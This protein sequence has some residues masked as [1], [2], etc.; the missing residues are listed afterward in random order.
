MHA[1]SARATPSRTDG[2]EHG[3]GRGTPALLT[4][5]SHP[6]HANR[7]W[8]G[9]SPPA[10]MCRL[11]RRRSA[12]MARPCG[13]WRTL[14]RP[15]SGVRGDRQGERAGNPACRADS[16]SSRRWRE[17]L[18]GGSECRR[19]RA[20]RGPE[21]SRPKAGRPA[22]QARRPGCARPPPPAFPPPERGDRHGRRRPRGRHRRSPPATW[23]ARPAPPTALLRRGAPGE[24]GEGRGQERERRRRPMLVSRVTLFCG[25]AVLAA[26]RAPRFAP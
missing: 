20:P 23:H 8:L 1:V 12:G 24:E 15:T 3:E 17:T 6:S 13:P 10:S 7:T 11:H 21:S 18:P 4:S 16:R 22:A 9:R 5:A 26:V 14:A 2:Q 19:P 25:V